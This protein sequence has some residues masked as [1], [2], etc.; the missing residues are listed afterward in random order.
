M[1]NVS[2]TAL[3]HVGAC[4][5]PLVVAVTGYW[6]PRGWVMLLTLATLIVFLLSWALAFATSRVVSLL[7]HLVVIALVLTVPWSRF[8]ARI[9]FARHREQLTAHVERVKDDGSNHEVMR[10][11]DQAEVYLHAASG[12]SGIGHPRWF[13]WVS[14]DRAPREFAPWND[15]MKLEPHWYWVRE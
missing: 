6:L 11:G 9:D 8:G 13:V 7:A 2:K 12:F 14:I 1:K 10:D 5:T 3:L 15:C 4:A